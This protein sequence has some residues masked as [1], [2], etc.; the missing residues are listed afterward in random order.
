MILVIKQILV[1]FE[2]YIIQNTQVCSCSELNLT[3]IVTTTQ[4]Y[5]SKPYERSVSIGKI[6]FANDVFKM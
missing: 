6:C 4:L 3:L 5:K 2:T 1:C